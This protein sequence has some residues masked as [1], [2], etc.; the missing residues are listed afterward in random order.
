MTAAFPRITRAA[1]ADWASAQRLVDFR[2]HAIAERVDGGSVQ[3]GAGAA[4]PLLTLHGFPTVSLDWWPLWPALTARGP[5]LAFDLL[6]FGRSAK[7]RGHAYALLEQADLAEARVRAQG[8]AEV[9]VLAHDYGD[10]VAQELMA[11]AA[12]GRLPFRLRRVVLLNGGIVPGAHRA[13]LV[14]RLLA[15]PLG[16]LVAR[17]QTRARFGASLAAVFAPATRPAE[18]ELDVFWDLLRAG[19]GMHAMPRLIRYMDERRSH[20]ARWTGLLRAPPCPWRFIDGLADPVSGAHMVDAVRALAPEADI[21][22]LPGVGHYPQL[23]APA[24]VLAATLAFL[25]AG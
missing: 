11:R 14:Q 10:S 15:G 18:E 12:E 9:D 7:P 2:G 24:A 6:G 16:P 1:A 13:R 22:G 21:V 8:W 4:T 5:V 25:D 23:E 3:G 17:A 20:Y 19:G